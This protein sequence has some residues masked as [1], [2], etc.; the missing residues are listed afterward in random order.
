MSLISPEN[1]STQQQYQIRAVASPI[2]PSA[3]APVYNSAYVTI[4]IGLLVL[5]LL[6]LTGSY[7]YLNTY[8]PH[9]CQEK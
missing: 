7:K 3:K 9:Y 4:Q 1:A 5:L 2:D 8:M 6:L